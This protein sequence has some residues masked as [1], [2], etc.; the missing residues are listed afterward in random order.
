M[1]A[2]GGPLVLVAEDE[3]NSRR[4]LCE[5]LREGGYRAV[6]AADGLELLRLA[7]AL[8]PAAVVL[9]LA[10]PRL[11]GMESAAALRSDPGTRDVRILAVTASWLAERGDL[12]AAA[13]FDGALRKPCAPDRLLEELRRVLA[14]DETEEG[15]GV[16]GAMPHPW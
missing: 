13:G 2:A 1:P 3:E 11:N 12:L 7:A 14:G 4:A 15:A 9:D 16:S 6:G 8:R 10:M 5:V